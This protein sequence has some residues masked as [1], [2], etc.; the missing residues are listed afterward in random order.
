MSG[1]R[2]LRGV[3]PGVEPAW[4]AGAVADPR[5]EDRRI[6]DDIL[7]LPV[8]DFLHNLHL[9]RVV[10]DAARGAAPTGG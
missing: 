4:P 5:G 10:E 7:C 1:V 3:A 8:T 9:A 6:T 2:R